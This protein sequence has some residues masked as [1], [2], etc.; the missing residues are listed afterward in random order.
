MA[1]TYLTYC[2]VGLHASL[3][4]QSIIW[5]TI[6]AWV[7]HMFAWALLGRGDDSVVDFWLGK[8]G[9]AMFAAMIGYLY[10]WIFRSPLGEIRVWGYHDDMLLESNGNRTRWERAKAVAMSW[11]WYGETG[12][13]VNIPDGAHEFSHTEGWPCYAEMRLPP[14]DHGM[15]PPDVSPVIVTIDRQYPSYYGWGHWL[16]SRAPGHQILWDVALL[17]AA[18]LAG[19]LVIWEYWPSYLKHSPWGTIALIVGYPALTAAL[20]WIAYTPQGTLWPSF[21]RMCCFWIGWLVM[22]QVAIAG[23]CG[24]GFVHSLHERWSGGAI[25]IAL[26][27]VSLP[28]YFFVRAWVSARKFGRAVGRGTHIY[29]AMPHTPIRDLLR[30]TVFVKYPRERHGHEQ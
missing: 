3:W 12:E 4:L 15:P 29:G 10:Y 11:L 7:G 28:L 2:L 5:A 17:H 19:L 9:T 13:G 30:P 6:L 18:G 27:S 14:R 1:L 8:P 23:G 22:M 20:A 21:W 26:A 25:P 24:F 16:L